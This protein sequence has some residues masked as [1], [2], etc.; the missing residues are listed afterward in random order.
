M[1]LIITVCFLMF[2][3]CVCLASTNIEHNIG[4]LSQPQGKYGIGYKDIFVINNNICPDK[5]YSKGINEDDFS[6][7]NVNY[8]HEINLR[9]YFPTNTL[10]HIG[11]KYYSPAISSQ[12]RFYSQRFHL[13]KSDTNLLNTLFNIRTY[14]SRHAH[15]SSVMKYPMIIFLP[16]SGM[17]V[18]SYNNLIGQLVSNGYIVLGV[19]SIFINGDIMLA[20]QHVVRQPVHYNDFG[21]LEN[22]NDLKFILQR[23][24][25]LSYGEDLKKQINFRKIGL[26]GHS[27][28]GMS[29][30]NLEPHDRVHI[31]AIILLDPGNVLESAN[32]PIKDLNTPTM[33][34]WSSKFKQLLH[35]SS[36]L[37][38]SRLEV[39]LT[40]SL[41]NVDYS[42]HENFSDLSTLQYHP[43]YNITE[44]KKFITNPKHLGVGLG[45]G[46][47]ISRTINTY[48]LT[49]FNLHLESKEPFMPNYCKAS[50]NTD[51]ATRRIRE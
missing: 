29:I 3:K 32:Y 16:G 42:N 21:R 34:I 51:V 35:G 45:D 39:V 6:Q 46:T 44:I 31:N 38:E 41:Q 18:Q 2:I 11:D 19:N 8:C 33:I 47:Q 1:K 24:K 27:M 12:I 23:L 10:P 26:L 5:F 36:K 30:V 50:D 7:N 13:S 37:H 20:D 14:N 28:G 15:V 43:A 4:Y 25:K 22:L 17:A 49:F 40:P 48:I 9:I